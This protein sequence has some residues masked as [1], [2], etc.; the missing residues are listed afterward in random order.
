MVPWGTSPCAST[1]Y[2]HDL[3][4][5]IK[6]HSSSGSRGAKYLRG[7][8]TVE[9]V[10]AKEYRYYKNVLAAERRIKRLSHRQKQELVSLYEKAD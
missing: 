3:E 10:Y 2:T 1:G 6:E 5:R 4:K 8:G 7:R 9:L